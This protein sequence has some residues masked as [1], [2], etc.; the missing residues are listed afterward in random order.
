[1]YCISQY[2]IPICYINVNIDSQLSVTKFSWKLPRI[3]VQYDYQFCRNIIS[4]HFFVNI[5][6]IFIVNS[7][8]Q[9][10][11]FKLQIYYYKITSL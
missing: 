6:N 3:L 11:Y 2:N 4:K 7:T 10:F 5:F 8:L 1:M 9:I